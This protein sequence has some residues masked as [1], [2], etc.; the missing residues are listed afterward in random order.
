M[1]KFNPLFVTVTWGTGGSTASRSLDLATACEL[2]HGLTTCLHLTCTNMDKLILDN[3]LKRAKEAG[4]RNI[5]ALRGDPPRGQEYR[6]TNAEFNYA[7]DLVKYIRQEYA[8]WFCIGVAA[9]PE[10]HADMTHPETLN[11]KD[12]LPW[13]AKKVR[14]GADFILT[15]LF[16]D[17]DAFA[18]FHDML[19]Q[20][21]A[22]CFTNIPLIPA[23]MPIQSYQTLMRMTSLSH[24]SL[25][26]DIHDRIDSVKGNDE[27]V[28]SVG[29]DV[30]VAMIRDIKQKTN[31]KV[32][33]SHFCTLNLERS[34]ARVLHESGLFKMPDVEPRRAEQ[35]KPTDGSIAAKIINGSKNAQRVN[36]LIEDSVAEAAAI[37]DGQGAKGREATWDEFPN[38][39]FGDSRSPAYGE[40][41][42]WGVSLGVPAK[43]ALKMW[44]SPTTKSDISKIFIDHINGKTDGTPWSNGPLSSETEVIKAELLKLNESQLWTVGSQPVVNCCPSGHP[45]FGWGPADGFIFQKAF[46]EFFASES[47]WTTIK[48]KIKGDSQISYYAGTR[49][50]RYESNMESSTSNAVTWGVF[51]GKEIAQP[52]IIEEESFKAWR[53]EAFA[54]WS[55][56]ERLYEPGSA[57]A[58]LL[59]QL[60]E[61]SWLVS[62]VHH[63]FK[64]E[65]ALWRVFD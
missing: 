50:G 46:V 35:I 16:Y 21:D 34:V 13:L 52:T 7:I 61:R 43:Q 63:D 65:R 23:I 15:Q 54:L 33:G 49:R 37:S 30:A 27:E 9:Y 64:D 29:V 24:A 57:T 32:R 44:G 53:D 3:A 59:R 41:D 5:L 18:A 48:E 31:N 2:E 62:I 28:K 47:Q 26:K 58:R 39:R 14:A 1:A 42:G 36:S 12:D 20:Y 4:I 19:L 17:T 40:L 45:E 25:P 38:G 51:P 8:D 60:E 56:W 11:P 6:T 10:G 55:E 22:E